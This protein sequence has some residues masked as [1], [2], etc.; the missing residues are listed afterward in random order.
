MTPDD[1]LRAGNADREVVV[2]RLNEAFGEGRLELSELEDRVAAA[3][4]A[5]TMGELRGLTT[6]LPAKPGDRGKPSPGAAAPQP[7]TRPAT[8]ADLRQAALE[9][10]HQR[11]NAKLAR[12][13]ERVQ[14]HQQR[15][16]RHQR[17]RD[18]AH[19]VTGFH[20][21]LA[22]ATVSVLCFTIW[23]VS[24]ITSGWQAPWFLWVAGPWGALLLVRHF[25]QRSS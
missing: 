18:L 19:Q 12:D 10:A 9:L 2:S 17:H 22:W 6:D 5:R 23:L 11:L 13:A 7:P 20:P 14:R 1:Q 4:A 8:V 16:A 21:V 15:L 24:S 3:Y 25:G